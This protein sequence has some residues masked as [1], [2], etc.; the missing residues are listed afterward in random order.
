MKNK[1]S[2][3]VAL[4]IPYGKGGSNLWAMIRAGEGV[5]VEKQCA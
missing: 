1:W 4:V 2:F 3:P 5:K